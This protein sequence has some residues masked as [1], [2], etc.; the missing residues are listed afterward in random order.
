MAIL[1]ASS[2]AKHRSVTLRASERAF[3]LPDLSGPEAF[4]AFSVRR[5]GVSSSPYDSLNFSVGQ[6]DTSDSV[7]TNF[8]R[9]TEDLE[10]E[11]KHMATC[12]QV[13]GDHIEIIRTIPKTP[14]V[15]DALITPIKG[16]FVAVKTA[17]C[18]P[19]LL[20][21]KSRGIASAVHAGW[22]GTVMR[23][24]PKVV[25][26]MAKEFGT[27]PEDMVAALGPAIGPCCYE[28]DD[29]V[30]N[31]FRESIPDP[32]RFITVVNNGNTASRR[33]DLALV[34]RFELIGKGVREEN[35]HHAN[36]CTCCNPD[37]FFSYRRDGAL[38]GRQISLTGFRI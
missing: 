15:A 13:H 24:L 35:I 4:M 31:P 20:L 27:K 3:T 12:K 23:I 14:P 38:S 17:D 5:G 7:R 18:L 16:V 32:E 2:I 6:G 26:R 37:L 28:V 9:L 25:D 36:L 11:P 34:N 10:I 21:D 1:P 30:L 8:D 22:R 33:I 29:K 19:V